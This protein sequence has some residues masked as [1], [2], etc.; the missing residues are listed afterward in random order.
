ME[1]SILRWSLLLA[2]IVALVAIYFVGARSRKK[3]QVVAQNSP[4]EQTEAFPVKVFKAIP[5]LEPDEED[6]RRELNELGHVLRDA[7]GAQSVG[8]GSDDVPNDVPNDVLGVAENLLNED[9]TS[10]LDELRGMETNDVA[11]DAQKTAAEER[12]YE[13]STHAQPLHE[14]PIHEQPESSFNDEVDVEDFVEEMIIVLYM[15]VTNKTGIAGRDLLKAA[16]DAGLSL[17]EQKVF[18]YIESDEV[19]FKVASMIEPG[20][21]PE[22]KMSTFVTPGLSFFLQIP[23]PKN[24]LKAFDHMLR[25]IDSLTTVF[26]VEVRDG[27]NHLLTLEQVEKL[28]GEIKVFQQMNAH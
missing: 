10:A 22:H 28:M 7:N 2:G 6:F 26:D 27:K 9:E 13:K 1:T 3:R 19:L 20:I 18:E 24:P 5:D 11:T 8:D 21:F 15:V 23:G 14:E 17:G 12:V 25:V 16:A 4:V